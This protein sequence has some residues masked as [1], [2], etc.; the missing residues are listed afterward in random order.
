MKI[1]PV[2]CLEDNYAY[3]YPPES[4]LGS[5]LYVRFLF[6]GS[7]LIILRFVLEE[8][9]TRAPSRRRPSTPWS[10]R[11]C[12]RRPRRSASAS[13]AYSPPT[14]TGERPSPPSSLVMEKFRPNVGLPEFP[15]GCNQC[16]AKIFPNP[17]L[18]DQSPTTRK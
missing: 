10:R 2:A 1:I 15:M 3:L 12:L 18:R 16:C 13:T 17:T 7:F 14:I 5:C 9:W 6:L 8:S 4:I 11:R